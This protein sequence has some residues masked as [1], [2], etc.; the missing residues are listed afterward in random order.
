MAWN[1][2]ENN[3]RG[4]LTTGIDDVA[5]TM[6]VTLDGNSKSYPAGISASTPIYLTLSDP[7]DP[8]L[9][10]I[11]KVTAVSGANVTTMVR[12]QRGTLAQT[13]AA[14][15]VVSLNLHAEDIETRQDTCNPGA[16]AVGAPSIY[17][18]T[19]TTTGPY[20]SAANEWALAISG[21]QKFK[22]SAGA[23]MV[24]AGSA[25]A[26]AINFGTAGTGL[27]GSSTTVD[28]AVAGT[29][30]A[31]FSSSG[32]SMFLD[33][34][35]QRDAASAISFYAYNAAS[36]HGRMN[37]YSARGTGASPANLNSEDEIGALMFRAW[38]TGTTFNYLSR[39]T[40]FATEAHS[41]TAGG[42]R[43]DF[44]VCPNTTIAPTLAMR[45]DQD[46]SI[47]GYGSIT[48]TTT[49]KATT[50]L[51][52]WNATPPASKPEITQD[53]STYSETSYKQLLTALASYGL[54]TDS[55]T[56]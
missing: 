10:E 7:D 55:T 37:F 23:L 24:P 25:A 50:S 36:A 5:T 46:K 2:L 54:I 3:V 44:Y 11:V 42:A 29:Q 14:H 31:S 48:A 32:I 19:D 4:R 8:L 47:L 13:W 56:T 21:V 27:Y 20:R 30:R 52:V 1:L 33:L 51:G 22:F 53:I 43:L 49:L 35:V 28:I 16:G 41:S 45:I 38:G 40:C 17:L 39:I 12:A 6:L 9:N 18:G 15:S 26:C 34:I